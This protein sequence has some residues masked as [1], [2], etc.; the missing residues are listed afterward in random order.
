MVDKL[1]VTY[2]QGKATVLEKRKEDVEF[3][4]NQIQ[5]KLTQKK[6]LQFSSGALACVQIK[7]RTVSGDVWASENEISFPV[8]EA[9]NTEIL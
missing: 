4:G 8:H 5:Y 1:I 9:F 6:T 3:D 7:I 2:R